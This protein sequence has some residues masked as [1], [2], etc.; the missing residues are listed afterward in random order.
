V[1]ED[2]LRS[3]ID[4]IL[5]G[6]IIYTDVLWYKENGKKVVLHPPKKVIRILTNINGMVT[7]MKFFPGGKEIDLK[8]EP[9]EFKEALIYIKN[10][11]Q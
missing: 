11:L 1:K 9:I 7:Y 2:Q 4:E 10:K 8:T 5:G 6:L 3:M